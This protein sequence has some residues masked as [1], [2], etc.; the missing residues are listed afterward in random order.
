[1]NQVPEDRSGLSQE[2]GIASLLQARR[3]IVE[4]IG[5][6]AGAALRNNLGR[7]IESVCVFE[8]SYG[9][10]DWSAAVPAEAVPAGSF[11]ATRMTGSHKPSD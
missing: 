2:T 10:C 1:M 11:S 5:Y 9:S 6:L 7:W 8:V 4:L 3:R